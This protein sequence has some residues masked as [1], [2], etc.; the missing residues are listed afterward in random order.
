MAVKF[1]SVRPGDVLWQRTRRKMGNTTMGEDAVFSVLVK[2]IL[3]DGGAMCSWNGNP[4][5]RWS[6]R[7]VEKLFRNRPKPKPNIFDRAR[8]AAKESR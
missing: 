4:A 2:E 7:D 5:R 8:E 3:P 1:D 6:V